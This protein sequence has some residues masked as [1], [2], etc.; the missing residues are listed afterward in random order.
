MHVFHNLAGLSGKQWDTKQPVSNSTTLSL[1]Y[2][3]SKVGSLII[4]WPENK[5]ILRH[6]LLQC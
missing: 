3:P 2:V 1:A 4:V 6:S 5:L